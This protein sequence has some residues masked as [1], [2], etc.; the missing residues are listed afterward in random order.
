VDTD[1]NTRSFSGYGFPVITVPCGFS[2]NGM[3]I[4][5]QIAAARW[6][7]MNAIALAQAY[8]RAT[9]WHKQKPKITPETSVP[10]LSKRAS[11]QTGD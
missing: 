8:E 11:E 2:K 3:P 6:N 10:V 1:E 5:L 9:E 4:G 7:E